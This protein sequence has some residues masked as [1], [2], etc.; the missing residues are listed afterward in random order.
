MI[1]IKEEKEMNGLNTIDSKNNNN[2]KKMFSKKNFQ[3]TFTNGFYKSKSMIKSKLKYMRQM[4]NIR[5]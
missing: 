5:N 1:S 2:Y 4:K 3:K